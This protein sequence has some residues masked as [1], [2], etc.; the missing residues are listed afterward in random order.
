MGQ[1]WGGLMCAVTVPPA[2]S[3]ESH[4]PQ[5]SRHK[6][7]V[8]QREV[9]DVSRTDC[10]ERIATST[11]VIASPPCASFTPQYN[12]GKTGSHEDEVHIQQDRWPWRKRNPHHLPCENKTR[13]PST[14]RKRVLPRHPICQHLT[15]DSDP[16][17]ETDRCLLLK[18]PASDG[19]EEYTDGPP[20]TSTNWETWQTAGAHPWPSSPSPL[21][22]LPPPRKAWAPTS[23]FP[24]LREGTQT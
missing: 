21:C 5:S 14:V 18:P 22:D 19:A 9:T 17:T 16:R 3:R 10:G 24:F 23:A 20:S 12:W 6:K 8:S 4:D 13:L 15:L 2:R 7:Q 1:S 11:H